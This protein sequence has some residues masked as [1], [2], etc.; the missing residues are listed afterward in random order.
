MRRSAAPA[1]R[2][3]PGTSGS[4]RNSS[5]CRPEA[6]L[7]GKVYLIDFWA[8]WCAPR[9]YEIPYI[10][11]AYEKYQSRGFEVI[12]YS[13]DGSREVVRKYLI[14]GGGEFVERLHDV[15]V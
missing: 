4:V 15:I 1:V 11:R 5:R 6:S 13:V 9:V 7:K 10:Q 3:T 2:L 12:S 14:H 8:T